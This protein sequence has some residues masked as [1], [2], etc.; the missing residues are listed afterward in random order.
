MLISLA[1]ILICGFALSDIEDLKRVGR[2]AIL[3]CFIPAT[4]EIIGCILLAPPLLGVTI[5]EAAISGQCLVRYP[6][7]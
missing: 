5:V 2:P 1:F 4:L 3:I 7:L 6:R